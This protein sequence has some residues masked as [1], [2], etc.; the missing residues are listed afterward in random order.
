ME[1]K[2]FEDILV[3]TRGAGVRAKFRVGGLPNTSDKC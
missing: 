3:E 1:Y 2:C